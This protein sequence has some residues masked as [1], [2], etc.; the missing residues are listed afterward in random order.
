VHDVG[1][2]V[3]TSPMSAAARL[4]RAGLVAALLLAVPAVADAQL[5]L[6]AQPHPE[7]MVGPL[8]L[9][10][11]VT[12]ALGDITIDVLFSLVVPPTV[13]PGE[14]DQD[15]YFLWPGAIASAPDAGPPDPA[16]ARQV[17]AQ[18]FSVIAEGRSALVARNL[19]Q[20]SS[21]GAVSETAD[22]GA[23]RGG[24]PFVTFVRE[25]SAIGLSAPATLFRI[26]WTPRLVNPTFLMDLRLIAHGMIKPKPA[27]WAERTFWGPRYRLSLSFHDVRQRAVFPMYFWNRE[28]VIRLAEDPA[29]IIINFAEAG[30]LKV[31]E[32]FPQSAQRRLS[33]SLED[34]DVI[35]L[36]LD[37]GDGLTPQVMAVQFGYFSGLQSWAPVLIPMLFF[38][39]GNLAAPILREI[40]LR[41]SRAITARVAFGR[42]GRGM[43]S[44]S[45]VIVPREA[46]A[47]I[48]PGETRYE[49]VLRIVGP[50][51]EEHEQIGVPDRKQL[52]YRGR[53]VVPHRRRRFLWFATVSGWDV[54]N[55]E[56]EIEVDR[57]VVADV[58]ARVR[59]TH[60]P[61]PGSV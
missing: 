18:G 32:M 50:S 58:Q 30:R 39:L 55:H 34:T 49:D 1:R 41:G 60:P 6:A 54:E 4:V 56:V 33:E 10:A 45:G 25:N 51:P 48:V 9:R 29:Q 53:R 20:V 23:V 52:V 11:N 12:P 24:V 47:K 15:L 37:R 14:L 17:E 28:R 13:T 2:V 36:F 38:A 44:D 42:A 40:G 35:S 59:R 3:T 16:L 22:A 7:F 31:D 57:G 5:F 8:F 26:P 21:E 19:Y 61:N 46:L 43:P 27:T